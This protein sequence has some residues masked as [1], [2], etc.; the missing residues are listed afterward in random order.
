MAKHR[1]TSTISKLKQQLQDENK[2]QNKGKD[3]EQ[4]NPSNIQNTQNTNIQNDSTTM[5][6]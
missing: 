4:I 3:T 6:Q 5:E 1:F 2:V